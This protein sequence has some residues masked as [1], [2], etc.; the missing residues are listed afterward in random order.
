MHRKALFKN[1]R[2]EPG[3]LYY[4]AFFQSIGR[5]DLMF[6]TMIVN[7]LMSVTGLAVGLKI[8]TLYSVSVGIAVAFTAH[9]LTV[10]YYLVKRGFGQSFAQLK[11]FVPEILLAA[12]ASAVSLFVARFLPENLRLGFGVKLAIDLSILVA[13]YAVLGQ[14]KYL[15][16]IKRRK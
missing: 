11:I 1:F 10:L 15:K 4:G 12:A 9:L 14:F 7:T 2:F 3:Y 13:G 8:G 6:R 5:T 16:L